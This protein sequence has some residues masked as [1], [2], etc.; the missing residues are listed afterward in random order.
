MSRTYT[1]RT[2]EERLQRMEA[3]MD[4][5]QLRITRTKIKMELIEEKVRMLRLKL[6]HANPVQS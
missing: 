4:K 1:K 5:H 2:P 3:Q 6:D